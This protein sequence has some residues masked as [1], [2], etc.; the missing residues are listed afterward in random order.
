MNN[1][2]Q[3]TFAPKAWT[4]LE[5]SE[6]SLQ[7]NE[8]YVVAA[9]QA[10]IAY[11]LGEDGVT[12]NYKPY[13]ECVPELFKKELKGKGITTVYT[14]YYECNKEYV[15]EILESLASKL[16]IVPI[17][18]REYCLTHCAQVHILWENKGESLESH[19][20]CYRLFQEDP[21]TISVADFL[22]DIQLNGIVEVLYD[23]HYISYQDVVSL[24]S[25]TEPNLLEP[26]QKLYPN[27][28]VVRKYKPLAE[29]D[30]VKGAI[31][32]ARIRKHDISMWDLHSHNFRTLKIEDFLS[33][34]KENKV[35]KIWIQ[36]TMSVELFENVITAYLKGKSEEPTLL[37]K[38]ES[39]IPYTHLVE[40]AD[41]KHVTDLTKDQVLIEDF[42]GDHYMFRV[43]EDV[44]RFSSSYA[45]AFIKRSNPTH[46]YYPTG[47]YLT[48]LLNELVNIDE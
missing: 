43:K 32:I 2:I 9:T 30:K 36:P 28:D 41:L 27:Y 38:T 12:G 34:L 29:S 37:K 7:A 47:T 4:T 15:V 22:N 39:L 25:E 44:F 35:F 3:V 6:I 20:V 26:V 1:S 23:R 24:F 19:S 40:V 21:K 45:A 31:E 33:Y 11:Y 8:A 48:P 10:I 18:K 14:D 42:G 46:V 17:S 13:C 5:P 16:R